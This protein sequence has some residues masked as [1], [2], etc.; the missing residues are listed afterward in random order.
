MG[1][2]IIGSL[3]V[4]SSLSM[5]FVGKRRNAREQMERD[6]ETFVCRFNPTQEAYIA[7]IGTDS[8]VKINKSWAGVTYRTNGVLDYRPSQSVVANDIDTLKEYLSDIIEK[9]ITTPGYP[10][11]IRY[12]WTGLPDEVVLYRPEGKVVKTKDIVE[13][14]WLYADEKMFLVKFPNSE[15]GGGNEEG[16]TTF[17]S[18]EDYNSRL[19]AESI[20]KEEARC[21]NLLQ[22]LNEVQT[23]DVEKEEQKREMREEEERRESRRKTEQERKKHSI[24]RYGSIQEAIAANSGGSTYRWWE[25]D[26]HPW[27]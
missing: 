19:R 16:R 12:E 17:E 4:A 18:L 7:V 22:R 2:L 15:D 24:D 5:Y 27:K 13:I 25:I 6:E 8:Q 26:P 21:E 9:R 11:Y 1:W 10:K 23:Y 20:K 14:N 3:I